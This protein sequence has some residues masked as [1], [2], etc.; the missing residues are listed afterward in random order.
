[1]LYFLS[2]LCGFI[3]GV[4]SVFLYAYFSAKKKGVN[5]SKMKRKH[6]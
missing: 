5:F 4:F 6:K 3:L 1:M 2:V